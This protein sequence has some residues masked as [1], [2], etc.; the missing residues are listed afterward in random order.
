[1]QE[2]NTLECSVIHDKG[3]ILL[4]LIARSQCWR[5]PDSLTAQQ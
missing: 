1:M 3:H 4:C 2:Q 5:S